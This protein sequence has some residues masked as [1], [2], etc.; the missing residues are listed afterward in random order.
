MLSKLL[1]PI[2]RGNAYRL[3][4]YGPAPTFK[5]SYKAAKLYRQNNK[6]L[7]LHIKTVEDCLAE[8]KFKSY[9]GYWDCWTGSRYERVENPDPKEYTDLKAICRYIPVKGEWE[10]L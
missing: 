8:E 7:A 9:F 4:K 1:E 5:E 3:E 10:A 6:Q 2:N